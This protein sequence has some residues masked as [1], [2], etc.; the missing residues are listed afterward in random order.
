DP[1]VQFYFRERVEP[2]YRQLVELLLESEP[3]QANLVLARK[4]IESLQL[5]E[6][7]NFLR[8]ACL[9]PKAE[10]DNIVEDDNSTAVIYPIVL[11]DRLE[12]IAK[13]SDQKQLL[14]FTIPIRQDQLKITT[15]T[16]REDLLDVTKTAQVKQKSQQLYGWLI[17][18]LETAL[19]Q[20]QI[21]TLV[22][23]LD[24]SLRNLPM[25]VLYDKKQQQ[26]LIEKYAIAVAPGLQLV[27]SKPLLPTKLNVLTAGISQQRMIAGQ[28]FS[29]LANVEQELQQIQSQVNK[30]QQLIDQEFTK[31]NL[32]ERLEET[33][34]STVH[35]A[36]HGKFSSNPEQTFILTWNQLL[37]TQDLANLMLPHNLSENDAIELL[38]LSACETATGDPLA[39]LGLAGIAVKAGVRSTLA[40]LWFADDQYSAEIMSSFYQE[41]SQGTTKAKA[42]QKA[43]IAVLKQ[44][45][46]PYLWSSF[47]LLGDWL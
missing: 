32:Q 46:R 36:T 12:I 29:S 42:L 9:E 20:N 16:L 15:A 28:D 13:L 23:V 10:I 41:L 22:F 18:P 47:I 19:M 30:S 4:T 14:H 45:K 25:S 35:L 37:K 11:T 1:K 39:A 33:N 3:S 24:G 34:F 7:E 21:D 8:Q 27:K 44:E 5:L 17:E 43:Q 26:Y 2:V 40:S 38:V 31:A 6:L